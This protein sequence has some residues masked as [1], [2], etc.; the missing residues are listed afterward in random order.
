M[1]ISYDAEHDLASVRLL[2]GARYKESVV[3]EDERF[4]G[5]I[6]IDLDLEGHVIGFEFQDASAVLPAKLLDEYR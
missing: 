4:F 2:E 6:V 5:P 3:C 1:K